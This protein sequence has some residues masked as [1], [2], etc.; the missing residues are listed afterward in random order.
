MGQQQLLLVVLGVIVVAV[1]IVVGIRLFQAQYDSAIVE[2]AINRFT[3]IG[4]QGLL[5]YKKP[6]SMGGGGGSFAGYNFAAENNELDYTYQTYTNAYA[7]YIEIYLITKPKNMSGNPTYIY[8]TYNT[9]GL[10]NLFVWN[11]ETNAWRQLR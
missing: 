7:T 8:G 11:Y 5:Y 2:L 1:A 10:Q 9:S 6:A 3:D 4:S